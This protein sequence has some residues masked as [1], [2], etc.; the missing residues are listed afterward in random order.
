MITSTPDRVLQWPLETASDSTVRGLG[1]AKVLV[2][3]PGSKIQCASLSGDGALL[4]VAG[5]N[6]SLLV[7]L[8][9]PGRPVPCAPGHVASQAALLPDK[10]WVAVTA[11]DVHGGPPISLPADRA[12][13][14]PQPDHDQQ[15]KTPCVAGR[16]VR[17]Q[18][19]GDRAELRRGRQGREWLLRGRPRVVPIVWVRL[20]T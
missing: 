17:R 9:E 7:D 13:D 1:V 6:R 2:S 15:P 20:D 11:V 19:A 8:N 3:A 16:R 5:M 14:P 10:R 18:R 12:G 4:A